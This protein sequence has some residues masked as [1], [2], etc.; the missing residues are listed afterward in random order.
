MVTE[1]GF[2]GNR[3]VPHGRSDEARAAGPGGAAAAGD[4][5]LIANLEA[6]V[7]RARARLAAAA[8]D[9]ERAAAAGIAHVEAIRGDSDHLAGE[10]DAARGNARRLAAAL[11]EFAGANAE[12]GR[13]AQASDRLVSAAEG[14]AGEATG[15]VEE[16][17]AAIG[18]IA[19]TVSQI[20]GIARQTN[21]LALNA[22]I[23]AARAGRSGAGFA[24]VASEVKALSVET[25]KATAAIA[26]RIE[27]LRAAA[28]TSTGAVARVI[29]IIG[30]IR[31]V[32]S[33]VAD[34]VEAQVGTIAEIGRTAA[35]AAGFAD[36]VAGRARSIRD[37]AGTA[38]E[39]GAAIGRT[40]AAMTGGVDEMARQ[41][42]TVL[43]Q[44]PMGDR[45]RH[46]RWPVEI[47]GRLVVAG[48]AHPTRTIDL[49]LGGALVAKG[50]APPDKG[51]RGKLELDGLGALACRVAEVSPLGCHLAFDEVGLPAVAARIE[52]I[53]AANRVAIERATR[54]ARAAAA[55]LEAALA[56]GRIRL[57]DLFDTDYRPIPGSDPP[58]YE[59]RALKALDALL[60]PLQEPILAED[61]KLAFACA[62][63]ING[64]LPVHNTRY[65]QPQRP[66]ERAWNVANCRNRRIF[67]DRAGLLAARNTRPHLVQAYA[68]DLGDRVVMMKEVDVPI[69]VAGRHW[70]GFRTAYLM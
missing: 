6:D 12:I 9:V 15:A 57:D 19:A 50:E 53:A 16:L 14:A 59:T 40:S 5:E 34:A 61:G 65:S 37:A 18:E 62:V 67:D 10:T 3:P 41:L 44:T 26:A 54:A 4:A 32:A 58:Q 39:A 45:R 56:A 30:D 70:G 51:A 63:D 24:V 52:A 49:S 47:P 8:G 27:R 46:D 33:A 2:D 36:D 64:Y 25:Q 60:P 11:D 48:R 38:A 1:V 28:E 7:R 66:G 35:E 31:P 21:L 55:A 22:T 13:T 68:R 20:A 23:E 43:R 29:G 42:L 17:R 69:H